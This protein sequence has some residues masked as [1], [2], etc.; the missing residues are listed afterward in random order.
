MEQLPWRTHSI[1]RNSPEEWWSVGLTPFPFLAESKGSSMMYAV[2]GKPFS[3]KRLMLIRRHS[4]SSNGMGGS[5]AAP[6]QCISQLTPRRLFPPHLPLAVYTDL[7]KASLVLVQ[8]ERTPRPLFPPAAPLHIP[9]LGSHTAATAPA[10]GEKNLR[11][12]P[13]NQPPIGDACRVAENAVRSCIDF[14]SIHPISQRM[15]NPPLL[16]SLQREF[17]VPP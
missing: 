14:S 15:I 2:G 16:S 6:R 1:C 13:P 12:R 9:P 3:L 7:L 4:V 10:L 5:A 8:R 11:V 17:M